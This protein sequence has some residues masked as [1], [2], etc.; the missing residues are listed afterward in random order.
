MVRTVSALALFS[1][2]S[3]HG[4]SAALTKRNTTVFTSYAGTLGIGNVVSTTARVRGLRFS[5]HFRLLSLFLR[6][7]RHFS[8]MV[9]FKFIL[10]KSAQKQCI[11]QFCLYQ[12]QNGIS[13]MGRS[14]SNIYSPDNDIQYPR[15]SGVG[16]GLVNRT[17]I[18]RRA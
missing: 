17:G 14:F 12:K 5:R 18:C 15:L 16:T 9:F 1:R 7:A 4:D 3:A 13:K 11:L 10:L 6:A 2:T 8:F